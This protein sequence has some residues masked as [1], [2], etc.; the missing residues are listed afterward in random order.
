MPTT[1]RPTE[2]ITASNPYNFLY[3]IF[4]L[5][6]Y[7]VPYLVVSMR[8]TDAALELSIAEESGMAFGDAE[9]DELYQR[10]VDWDR[11]IHS[12]APYLKNFNRPQFFNAL[13]VA[14]L[15]KNSR[16]QFLPF[17]HPGLRAPTLEGDF[18]AVLKVGPI[19][20]G[21]YGDID[22]EGMQ[23]GQLI[24][25]KDQVY[26]LAIDGQHRLAALKHLNGSQRSG[27]RLHDSSITVLLVIPA[28]AL[29]LRLPDDEGGGHVKLMR[30]LFTD[31]NKHAV[32]VSRTRELLLDDHDPQSL[33]VRRLVTRS[34]VDDPDVDEF[35]RLSRIPL[36]LVD[37]H[38]DEAKF[39][40]G[41]Y[42]T[43]LLTLDQLVGD[44]T[45]IRPVRD[46]TDFEEV[47]RCQINPLKQLGWQPTSE[48]NARLGSLESA[49]G[50]SPFSY[51]REDL[52]AAVEA[53]G[54]TWAY[55]VAHLLTGVSPY[56][57]LRESRG[58]KGMLTPDFVQWYD[59]FHSYRK[60]PN[61]KSLLRLQR[62]L[63]RVQA[64]SLG[65]N[66][67]RDWLPWVGSESSRGS[68]FATIKKET[69]F[70]RVVFQKALVLTLQSFGGCMPKTLHS[71][72][73][74][75]LFPNTLSPTGLSYASWSHTVVDV[76][77]AVLD[78]HSGHDLFSLGHRTSGQFPDLFWLGSF[79]KASDPGTIDFTNAA[80]KRGRHWIVLMAVLWYTLETAESGPDLAELFAGRDER[81]LELGDI[82][83]F[84]APECRGLFSRAAEQ[85]RGNK[86]G[87]AMR[88][89]VQA[90]HPNLEDTDPDFS[91]LLETAFSRRLTHLGAVVVSAHGP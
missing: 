37:W 76:V 77:N 44:L 9:L 4:Q 72:L 15:P 69:L 33:F 30:K 29:G 20:I 66:P 27:L 16:G 62:T 59:A 60:S 2:Q 52:A 48:C 1:P 7:A 28:P 17:D 82:A 67:D 12:I 51:P 39:H 55:P 57:E 3:G 89:V 21:F 40:D 86:Q 65:I 58:A 45:R 64:S 43:S 13:T 61:E 42:C 36:S 46:W 8:L 73:H 38:T 6:S 80:A 24:W 71:A 53:F 22:S 35:E 68:Q 14:V 18:D 79:A 91:R 63:D 32:P 25:N 11:A 47:T 78:T 5:S 87:R 85:L 84:V 81:V 50:P 10:Q 56:M 70:F 54:A 34:L 31:L 49:E 75:P 90:T 83:P 26:A 41:P 19:S 88:Y 74:N 23:I